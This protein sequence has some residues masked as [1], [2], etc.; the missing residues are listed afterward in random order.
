[1]K[2][3]VFAV[4]VCL[5]VGCSAEQ[6]EEFVFK[7]LME[8]DLIER[9]GDEN[10]ECIN[11]VKSQLVSCMEK[12]NWREIL[13]KEEDEKLML[14]FVKKFYPCFKDSDGNSHFKI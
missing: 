8:S 11:S 4:I 10:Q 12:S 1:M 14:K 7:N 3:L 9:C 13:G 5:V 6:A 2:I